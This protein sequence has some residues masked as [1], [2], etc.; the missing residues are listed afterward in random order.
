[1]E[2]SNDYL[3]QSIMRQLI[4]PSLNMDLCEKVLLAL[5]EKSVPE[6]KKLLATLQKNTENFKESAKDFA[7]HEVYEELCNKIRTRIERCGKHFKVTLADILSLTENTGIKLTDVGWDFLSPH[8]IAEMIDENVIGQHEYTS[9]LALCIYLHM[10]RCKDEKA[11]IPK[12]NMLVYGPSGVGKTYSVQV[13]AKKMN[14]DF[15]IVNSNMLVQEGIVGENITDA[16]TNAYIKNNNL[17]HLGIFFDEFDELFKSGYYHKTILQ[18]FL[19]ILDDNREI[20]F[21]T[22]F[23]RNSYYKKI[24]TRNIMIILGGVFDTLEPIVNKRLQKMFDYDSS[25]ALPKGEFYKYVTK[26]DFGKLFHS[27]EL[28]GRIGQ[29]VRVKSMTS[30]MLLNILQ[31]ESASPLIPYQNYFD[32]HDCSLDLTEGAAKMIVEIV[33]KQHLGVRGLKSTL[34]NILKE[35]MMLANKNASRSIVIDEQ[36]VSSHLN[37]NEQQTKI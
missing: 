3:S 22:S 4:N 35:D 20:S 31:S 18:E 6:K 15:E 11:N 29:F 34:G 1:M 8:S 9:T 27:D 24:S 28:L 26:E 32:I 17:T 36:Y 5:N 37:T 14:I 25:I 33:E 19:G 10:L 30:D 16:I 12:T 7:S 13:L 23:D 2:T 21:R